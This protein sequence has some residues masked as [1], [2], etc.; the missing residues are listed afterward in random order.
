M[1]SGLHLGKTESILFG[2]TRKLKKIKDF[3]VT[4]NGQTINNQKSVKYLGV[5]LDQELSG[6]AMRLLRKLMQDSGSCTGRGISWLLP[7]GK[8]YAIP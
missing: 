3:F 8:H 1:V 4:C 7:Y 6:E 5:M 2:S